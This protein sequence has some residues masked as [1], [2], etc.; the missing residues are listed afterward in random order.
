MEE[1]MRPEEW[2]SSIRTVMSLY[3]SSA[4]LNAGRYVVTGLSRS[5]LPFSARCMTAMAV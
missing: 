3:R 4:I 2:F 1:P 5:S